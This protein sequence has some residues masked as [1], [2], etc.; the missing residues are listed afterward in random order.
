MSSLSVNNASYINS[1]YVL[2]RLEDI[3]SIGHNKISAR[4]TDTMTDALRKILTQIANKTK[5]NKNCWPS[6]YYKK[7]K[8]SSQEVGFAVIDL[9]QRITKLTRCT[10]TRLNKQSDISAIRLHSFARS[11]QS[12]LTNTDHEC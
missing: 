4:K 6:A 8:N 2:S 12:N 1:N 11:T 7:R 9:E 10:I 3:R 5:N